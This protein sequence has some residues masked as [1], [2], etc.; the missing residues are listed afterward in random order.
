MLGDNVVAYLKGKR[1]RL[2]P[3]VNQSENA[4]DILKD[5]QKR[6]DNVFAMY[7]KDKELLNVISLRVL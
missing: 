7:D 5:A 3:N 4:E 6:V 2:A 1:L